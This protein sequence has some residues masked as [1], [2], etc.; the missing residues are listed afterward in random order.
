ML[1]L[2]RGSSYFFKSK[3]VSKEKGYKLHSKRPLGNKNVKDQ[4][5]RDWGVKAG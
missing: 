3:G 2:G 4:E 5:N 1:L